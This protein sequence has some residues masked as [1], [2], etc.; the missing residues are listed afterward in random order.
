MHY[1]GTICPVAKPLAV[2]LF[3]GLGAH[4][5]HIIRAAAAKRTFEAS[6]IIIRAEESA[7][8]LFVIET[9]SVDYYIETSDG[10]EILLSRLLPGNAF[11]FAAF[12]TEPIGYLGTAKA[13]GRTETLIWE[14]R[15]VHQ[16]AVTYP[17]LEENALHASLQYV[18]MY[19]KRLIR[20]VSNTAQMRVAYALTNLGSRSGRMLPGGVEVDIKNE[21]L[22]SL[23]DVNFFT[24]SRIIRAWKQQNVVSKSRGKVLIRCPEK[25]IAALPG[26]Q[27]PQGPDKRRF[28]ETTNSKGSQLR[29]ADCLAQKL[30]A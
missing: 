24:V 17:R 25:M 11:G 16:L 1:P 26:R 28:S 22:A 23:A 2:A 10:R 14:H 18:A 20:L 5:I 13:A 7:V 19:A 21:D 9:G 4:E 30:R 15:V 27:G 3:K 8:R 29:K 6:Q 12:L